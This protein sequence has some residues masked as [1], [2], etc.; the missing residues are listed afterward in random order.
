MAFEYAIINHNPSERFERIKG[1]IKN[2]N[3]QVRAAEACMEKA[4]YILQEDMH[5][6]MHLRVHRAIREALK[7]LRDI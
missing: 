7:K 1:R 3:T 6:D 4:L 2:V 5:S